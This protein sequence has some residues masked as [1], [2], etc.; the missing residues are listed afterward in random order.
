MTQRSFE[1]FKGHTWRHVFEKMRIWSMELSDTINTKLCMMHILFMYNISI[2]I[3][4]LS[5]YKYNVFHTYVLIHET[6][7]RWNDN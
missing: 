5:M 7:S 4:I 2:Y 1:L 6:G 3:Y